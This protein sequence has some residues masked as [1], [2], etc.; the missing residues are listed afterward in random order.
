[1][2]SSFGPF[3]A[4]GTPPATL[5]SGQVSPKNTDQQTDETSLAARRG[6]RAFFS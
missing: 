5:K 1:M 4:G 3:N 6:E 2:A